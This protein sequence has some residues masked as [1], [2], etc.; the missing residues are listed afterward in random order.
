[1]APIPRDARAHRPR[2][3]PSPV[4]LARDAIRAR[5]DSITHIRAR[6]S[7]TMPRASRPSRAHRAPIA[8]D[9]NPRASRPIP[10]PRRS[11]ARARRPTARRSNA[12][13]FAFD[14]SS[15]V[16]R[17]L[18]RRVASR[19]I[20]FAVAAGKGGRRARAREVEAEGDT[21]GGR[22]ARVYGFPG[23]VYMGSRARVMEGW[24]MR[25]VRGV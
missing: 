13:S 19:T 17:L 23:D 10:P 6:A 2:P 5:R 20:G 21:V 15:R 14:A 7:S 16:R 11:T 12:R 4:R 8:R 24:Y 22:D 9:P 25:V 1:L 18:S 3:R